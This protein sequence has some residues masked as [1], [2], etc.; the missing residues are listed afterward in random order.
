MGHGAHSQNTC[1]RG[2][3]PFL[4]SNLPGVLLTWMQGVWDVWFPGA[5]SEIEGKYQGDWDADDITEYLAGAGRVGGGGGNGGGVLQMDVELSEIS[6]KMGI[7]PGI[8]YWHAV[9]GV[10][11]KETVEPR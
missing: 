11:S 1:A 8:H 3:A 6:S 2:G 10:G 4:L 7:G 9:G 5:P